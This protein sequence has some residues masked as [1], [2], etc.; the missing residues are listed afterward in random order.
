M[1]ELRVPDPT[2]LAAAAA[3]QELLAP[4]QVILNGSRAVGEHRPDSDVDLMAVYQD[5]TARRLVEETLFGLPEG[6]PPVHVYAITRAEFQGMAIMAQSFPG[7]AARYGVTADG[8]P[9]NY[10]PERQPSP[11]EIGAGADF[12]KCL[13][14]IELREFQLRAEEKDDRPWTRRIGPL[15]AQYA[16]Q[17]AIKRLLYLDNDSVRY[18]RDIAVMWRHIQ[19][20]R[21]VTMPER[22]EAVEQLLA[23]TA[24]PGGEGCLLTAFIHAHRRHLSIPV[25][26]E[27]QWASLCRHLDPAVN[28]LLA[29][30]EDRGGRGRTPRTDKM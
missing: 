6:E 11:V 7:Q 24:E 5:E 16:M 27:E 21:P 14:T 4:A 28:A 20:V 1:S 3:M 10:R 2:G 18:R 15:H 8:Q 13:C 19:S 29:E 17:R 22:I 12:W 26:G 25:L 30:A 9:L 23:A